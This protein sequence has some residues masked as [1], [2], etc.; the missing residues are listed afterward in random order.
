L[1]L[2]GRYPWLAIT[3]VAVYAAADE[4]RQLSLPG[5]DGNVTDFA[6]DLAAALTAVLALSALR[7]RDRLRDRGQ[8]EVTPD[9]GGRRA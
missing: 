1:A 7:G 8:T 2:D 5:R 4:L 9:K 6:T 3:L